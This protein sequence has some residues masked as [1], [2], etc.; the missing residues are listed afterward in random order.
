MDAVV[1]IGGSLSSEPKVLRELCAVLASL[2]ARHEIVVVPGGGEFADAVRAIDRRYS[3]Q[4]ETAHKM[5]I[6]GMDQYGLLLSDLMPNSKTVETIVEA[7]RTSNTKKVA[8]FLP[9]KLISEEDDVEASWDVTSDTIAAYISARLR[10]KN[11]VLIKDVDGI[12]SRDPNKEPQAKLIRSVRTSDLVHQNEVTCV[13]KF[14]PKMLDRTKQDCFVVNGKN[15]DRI[16]KILKG[17]NE[18]YTRILCG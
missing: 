13:D 14:L 4:P 11:L 6:L 3:L 5:A 10:A 16:E 2:S 7:L 8:I 18:V 12:F 15:P 9:F 17:E 1:K